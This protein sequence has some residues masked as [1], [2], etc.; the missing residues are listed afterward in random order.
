MKKHLLLSMALLLAIPCALMAQSTVGDWKISFPAEDGSTVQVKLSVSADNTYQVDF[1]IDGTVEVSG[2]MTTSG[3]EMTIQ[4][5]SGELACTG[6]NTKGSY[7]FAVDGTTMVMTKV[8]DSC[9]GRAPTGEMT[10]TKM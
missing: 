9:P 10:F 7:T 3:N 6:D 8:S 4:D 2:N 5:V 1:G